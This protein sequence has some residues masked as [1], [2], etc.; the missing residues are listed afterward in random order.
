MSG[1]YDFPSSLRQQAEAM[2]LDG[3]RIVWAGRPDPRR[4]MAGLWPVVLFGIPWTA[5]SG[6]FMAIPIAALLGLAEVKGARDLPG[7][8]AFLFSI[9]F[10][11]VGL[12]LVSAPYWAFRE[13]SRSGF[14]VTDQRVMKLTEGRARSVKA[15][16]A[17]TLRGAE[18]T[19]HHDGAG[20][21]K[22]LGPVGRDSDGDPKTD[23][24]T[25]VGVKDPL[26]AERAIWSL[27][28]R[29]GASR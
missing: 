18:M 6:S 8:I 12:A 17:R 9:P 10:V 23:D 15:L 24:I 11:L 21:V 1:L 29:T 28:G 19:T 5:L 22:A 7:A 13:A 3:E 26:G 2:L 20:T 4:S 25:M 14:I 27:I 16:A